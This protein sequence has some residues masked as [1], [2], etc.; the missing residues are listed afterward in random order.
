MKD[1]VAPEKFRLLG[2]GCD[3]LLGAIRLVEADS[4]MQLTASSISSPYMKYFIVFGFGALFF[5]TIAIRNPGSSFL[6]LRGFL[7]FSPVFIAIWLMALFADWYARQ[8]ESE[9]LPL[10]VFE[11]STI[12]HVRGKEIRKDCTAVE[13]YLIHAFNS[14]HGEV[15][16]LQMHDK[17]TFSERYMV[18]SEISGGQYTLRNF[19]A[20]IGESKG[21]DIYFVRTDGPQGRRP[22]VVKS[23]KRMT[24]A[25]ARMGENRE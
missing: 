12:T 16:E 17:R 25:H 22:F 2:G 23:A 14:P 8:R 19:L 1:E 21:I 6:S 18:V 5:G 10:L 4:N 7:F 9:V 15:V 13:F 11:G 24:T 3:D 20:R